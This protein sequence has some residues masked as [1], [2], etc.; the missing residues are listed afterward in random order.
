M[1]DILGD[2]RGEGLGAVFS[3]KLHWIILIVVLMV[4]A[5]WVFR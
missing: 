2:I 5:F 3:H 4:A 1:W